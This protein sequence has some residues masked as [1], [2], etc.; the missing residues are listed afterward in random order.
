M[1][2]LEQERTGNHCRCKRGKRE[3]ADSQKEK[4]AADKLRKVIV[5]GMSK[6][7]REIYEI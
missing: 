7:E 3:Q 5:N 6:D 1:R 4:T 2:R